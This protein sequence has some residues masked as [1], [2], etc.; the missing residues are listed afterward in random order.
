MNTEKSATFGSS[1]RQWRKSRGLSQLEL[2]LT[3]DSS[4]RHLSFLENGRALPSRAMVLRLAEALDVPLRERNALLAAAGFASMFR[5][6]PLDSGAMREVQRALRLMLN[7]Q[8]PYP[9]LVI[10]RAWGIVET[11]A[12]CARLMALLG[13]AGA[14]GPLNL[15]RLMMHPNGM[16]QW[17]ED[18]EAGARMLLLQL[19]RELAA[20]GNDATLGS[21]LEEVLGYPDVAALQEIAP[22]ARAMPVLPLTI[23]RD[24][25]RLSWF[26]TVTT[27]G[28]PQ[29][30]TMQELRIEMFYP[31]DEATDRFSRELA[32][33]VH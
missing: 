32:A 15:L 29:D 27:F 17:V 3:A 16:R 1:L 26:T 12:A 30:I 20:A 24:S 28:T 25:L 6:T 33:N 18:W 31:A 14:D 19:R 13:V 9:A 22:D 7:K 5:E 21:L 11:N 23:A 4:A 10:D 8:E 2:A